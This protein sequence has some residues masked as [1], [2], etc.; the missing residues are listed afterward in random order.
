MIPTEAPDLAV[1]SRDMEKV[2][3]ML[4]VT[5]H[6]IGNGDADRFA[7]V[8]ENDAHDELARQ[9]VSGL[10]APRD[11]LPST[12]RVSITLPKTAEQSDDV[13]A[14]IERPTDDDES[15]PSHNTAVLPPSGS[16]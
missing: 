5:V 9:E 12:R 16:H 4:H 3:D 7:L 14:R 6:N 10:A 2:R 11:L 1:M 8:V 13:R 15:Y